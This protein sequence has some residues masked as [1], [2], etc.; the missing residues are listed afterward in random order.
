MLAPK[1]TN[2]FGDAFVYYYGGL[3]S[4]GGANVKYSYEREVRGKLKI[5][6]A[7][8]EAVEI[9]LKKF[10]G[11]SFDSSKAIPFIEIHLQTIGK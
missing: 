6:K 2:E 3:S 1:V 11:P 10:I 4:S 9:D 5:H 7:G 8:Y